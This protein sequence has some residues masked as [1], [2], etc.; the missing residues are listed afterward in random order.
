MTRFV[1]LSE[2]VLARLWLCWSEA[3]LALGPWPRE[4]FVS[5]AGMHHARWG[6]WKQ[7]F[8]RVVPVFCL[9]PGWAEFFRMTC[10]VSGKQ[11]FIYAW[12]IWPYPS[13][14]PSQLSSV[15]TAASYDIPPAYLLLT[16]V[17]TDA[18]A[19]TTS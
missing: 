5:C 10:L 16:P 2:D 9:L 11:I 19:P 17:P 7:T 3:E 6:F 4:F 15:I 18:C 13:L 12:G 14:L 8:N 1:E